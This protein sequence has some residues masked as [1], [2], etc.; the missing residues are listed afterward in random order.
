[1]NSPTDDE[2]KFRKP[3]VALDKASLSLSVASALVIAGLIYV[4]KNVARW[5]PVNDSTYL[6]LR[7]AYRVVDFLRLQSASPVATAV[8]RRQ[9]PSAAERLGFEI[10]IIMTLMGIAVAVSFL[11]RLV[12]HTR[13]Y[14]VV[15]GRSTP[16]VLL[17]AAPVCYLLVSW[18]MWSWDCDDPTNSQTGGF[19]PRSV[20]LLVFIGEMLCVYVLL[21]SNRRMPKWTVALLISFH[22]AYWTFV[23]WSAA[24]VWLFPIYTRDAV[25][26]LIPSLAFLYLWRRQIPLERTGQ[27]RTAIWA[28]VLGLAW[29][30]LC[31]AVWAPPR[32]VSLSNPRDL[33]ATKIELARGPCFG[34]CPV[35][36]ITVLGDG[37]VEYWGRQKHSRFDT[38]KQGKIERDKVAQILQTLDKV[39]FMTLED[40]AFSWG[41]DSPSVGVRIWE[42]GKAKLVVS[43]AGFVG[44]QGGHQA[45][46]VE[47]TK[48]IDG[49]LRA[50]RWS[51]C[52][53]E[54]CAAESGPD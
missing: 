42:D 6:T 15:V 33:S 13:I 2:R 20:P 12:S 21:R 18:M 54:E 32:T 4:L 14:D 27:S 25:L 22:F 45:R 24:R 11:L 23:L 30:V 37:R 29:L 44:S 48:E 8:L 16:G 49:I 17:F 46:F 52:E 41:F 26:L 10:L 53:G 5:T 51:Y 3:W 35:Y 50:T 9:L 39:K 36:T 38:R 47:A 43:D 28:I 19:F 34:P 7:S 40:R 1:M 31:G